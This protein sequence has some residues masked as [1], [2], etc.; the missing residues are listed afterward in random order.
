MVMK[1]F[2]DDELSDFVGLTKDR[3]IDVR[4]IEYMPFQGNEWKENKMISFDTMKKMIREVYPD[5]QRFSNEYN[6]T[7]KVRSNRD[8]TYI[9]NVTFVR[10]RITKKMLS[11]CNRRIVCPDL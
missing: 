4:F 2:N 1:G 10:L 11:L 8:Y 7:S 5:L 9:T 6:D 3:P